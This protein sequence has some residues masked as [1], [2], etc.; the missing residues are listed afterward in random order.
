M[1]YFQN[2]EK[3]IGQITGGYGY[4]S[5]YD[6]QTP[7]V[8][9]STIE[10]NMSSFDNV[11]YNFHILYDVGASDC[12]MIKKRK[13]KISE[14]IKKA[15]KMLIKSIQK[16]YN[17][18]FESKSSVTQTTNSNNKLQYIYSMGSRSS[19]R[20]DPLGLEKYIAVYYEEVLYMICFETMYVDDK[21]K[22]NCIAGKI[23][24][25]KCPV[26]NNKVMYINKNE[27]GEFDCCYPDQNKDYKEK[28][29]NR[30]IYN[31]NY[32]ID[33]FT[34]EKVKDVINDFFLK[35]GIKRTI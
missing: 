1:I 8:L 31:S 9:N 12:D 19:A 30:G 32:T 13:I 22:V 28:N 10:T 5:V 16:E 15:R 33:N 17:K 7:K 20:L 27:N 24:Y 29:D 2:G 23:Q 35:C 14:N 25:Y 6:Y 4:G 3:I 18:I 26:K 34:P 21:K 11:S